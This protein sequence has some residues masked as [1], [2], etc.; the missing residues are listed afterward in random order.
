MHDPFHLQR[1][2]DAQEPVYANVLRELQAGLKQS[3][4]MWFVFPQIEGLGFSAMSARYAIHSSA[5]AD[6]YLDFPLLGDRLRE[7]AALVLAVSGRTALDIFGPIDERKF[8]S[9]MTLFA[10]VQPED[11]VFAACLDK[12]FAGERDPAT[13]ARL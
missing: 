3:H 5:E 4:W 10:E 9:S 12:Y 7:C 8:R 11:D 6:A 2:V 1:F 13:L